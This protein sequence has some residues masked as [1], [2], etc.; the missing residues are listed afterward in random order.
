V[1]HDQCVGPRREVSEGQPFDTLPS[2]IAANGDDGKP[3]LVKMDIEGAEWE[4]LLATPDAVL[5]EFVQLPMELHL[6]GADEATFVQVVRRLKEH[7]FLVNVHFNNWSCS[8]DSAPLP[9]PAFQ[10][11]WV[12]KRV[13]VLDSE[14]PA[15]AGPLNAP[16]NPGA[17]ECQPPMDRH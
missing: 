9:S 15:P 4:S 6:R 8:S 7:F 1:F 2:Q 13:D 14:A 16:D 11:L 12:N 10:V 5:D 17:P 3:L